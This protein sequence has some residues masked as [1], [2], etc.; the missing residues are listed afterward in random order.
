MQS[1]RLDPN[2][3]ILILGAGPAGLACAM[4]LSRKGIRSTIV[5]RDEQIGGLAKTLR[6]AEGEQVFLTDIGPHRF[7][8]KNKYLYD[9]IEDL[10]HEEWRKVP[11]LTRQ[12]I[13]GKFYNY[14]VNPT[15]VFKNL[16]PWKS[17]R[18][19]VDY[20]LARLRYGLLR[21]PM[22]TFEDYVVANFGRTLAEFSMIN[23]TEK[24]WGIPARDIHPDWARQRISGLN[25]W[26]VLMNALKFGKRKGGP[27]SLVDEF[28]YPQF[29]TG[30]IYEE[31][32]RH[33]RAEGSTIATGSE[34]VAVRHD[35]QRIVEVD[36]RTPEGVQTLRPER[37]VESVPI[38]RFLDLLD[39]P[40][41]P[42]VLAAARQLKWRAQ[43]YLFLTL[44]KERVTSDNW[45]YFPSKDIPFGRTSEMKNFSA[46]MCPPGKTSFFVEF[47]AFETDAI[48]SMT[49]EQVL[50]L[51]MPYFEAWG[52]FTRQE[53]RGCHL[54]K[55]SHVYPVYDSEYRRR[56]D[57]VKAW[58]DR[59][60][61]LIYVGR[62]GR[63]KYTNQDHSLEMGIVA[64]RII[65]EGRQYDMEPIGAENEYF[66]K[67]V[68]YEKRL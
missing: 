36:V 68:I 62:P 43:V 10:L 9:F 15:Q 56:L 61:N 24:I 48:W 20:F 60:Q 63:F 53:V 6:I 50:D 45:I 8:S 13:D 67:G 26:S 19:G 49:K 59:L 16:G 30:R 65:L 2:P 11:R 21:K 52:F 18:I 7:F 27:K 51:V 34:P 17:L 57:V 55:R 39:P 3:Q 33:L 31:I 41:P 32:G 40:P 25:L 42:E 47:F 22:R 1:P 58:L 14:P 64:S 38:T 28:Y 46:D 37:V 44:D 23:Y 4:E 12:F 66:E 5:E 54:M 29:G 35:G